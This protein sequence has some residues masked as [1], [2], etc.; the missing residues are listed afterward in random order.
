MLDMKRAPRAAVTVPDVDWESIEIRAAENGFE[1]VVN[2]KPT[3]P[4]AGKE[5]EVQAM[6]WQPGKKFLFTSA[7]S[8][9]RFVKQKFAGDDTAPEHGEGEDT[10]KKAAA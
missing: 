2:P 1:V 5:G 4:K 10:K 8:A 7:A 6:G 9:L 3:P